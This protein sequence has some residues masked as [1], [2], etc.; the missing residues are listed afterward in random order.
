MPSFEGVSALKCQLN[1]PKSTMSSPSC[2]DAAPLRDGALL[3]GIGG[4]YHAYAF[5]FASKKSIL[6]VIVVVIAIVAVI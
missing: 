4:D 1:Q 6:I 2:T 3:H 5:G